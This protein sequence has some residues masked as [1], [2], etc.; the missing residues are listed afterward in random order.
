MGGGWVEVE[1][2]NGEQV[3][4]LGSLSYLTPVLDDVIR[5]AIQIATGAWR[6]HA[7]FELEPG[8]RRLTVEQA[9]WSV[10]RWVDQP[11][12]LVLDYRGSGNDPRREDFTQACAIDI[13]DV[14]EFSAAVLHAAKEVRDR[15]GYGGY[16]DLW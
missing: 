6:A 7:D 5:A 11:R 14:A 13:D 16:D 10:D 9:Y 15:H 12:V 3:C 2:A 8:I 1:I 4:K